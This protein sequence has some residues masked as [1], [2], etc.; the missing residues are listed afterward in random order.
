MKKVFILLSAVLIAVTVWSQ[1]PQKLSYQA[2]IR[3][4]SNQLVT[5]HAVGI[6]ISILQGSA[7]GTAVYVETQT[8]TS[9]ANGL[10]DIEIGGGTV[11]S[12]N[13]SNIDWSKG[14]YYIKTESD[15]TGGVSYTIYGTSQILSTPYALYS[16]KAGKLN[17][18]RISL[19]VY[20]SYLNGSGHSFGDGFG[21]NAGLFLNDGANNDFC[22]NFT[23]PDDYTAGDTLYIRMVMSSTST[24][25]TNLLPNW[26]SVARPGVGF[27]TG[28]NVA[29]GLNIPAINFATANIPVEIIGYILSPVTTTTILPGD[30]I[31]F[32]FYRSNSDP[33]TGTL[34]IHSIEIIYK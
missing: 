29:T 21:A 17:N 15:P 28:S 20:G 10:I 12:G 2:V 19:N 26:I 1:S 32:S 24:G 18:N 3:N 31:S 23:V 4:S 33:N 9:N 6:K 5:S 16:N 25:V 14:P 8:P 7:S 30:A 22:Q 13:F 11:V 27:I 34:K